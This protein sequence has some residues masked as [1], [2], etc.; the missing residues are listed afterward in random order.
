MAW[1]N[2]TMLKQPRG[3]RNSK[4]IGSLKGIVFEMGEI[5]GQEDIVMI[6]E[7]L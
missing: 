5:F 3:A 6:R 1:G 2:F 4:P 7:K